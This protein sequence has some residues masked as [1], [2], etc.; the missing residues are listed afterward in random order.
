MEN[1]IWYFLGIASGIAIA[2]AIRRDRDENKDLTEDEWN[3]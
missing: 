2:V 3:D 1:F